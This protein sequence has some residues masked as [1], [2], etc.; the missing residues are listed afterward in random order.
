MYKCW[1]CGRIMPSDKER[2]F[3]GLNWREVKC[4]CGSKIFMKVRLQRIKRVKA[5]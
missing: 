2:E 4:T 5:I 1:K 3:L